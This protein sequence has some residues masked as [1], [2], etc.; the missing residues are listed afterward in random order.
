MKKRYLVLQNGR[1]F[2]GFAFGASASAVGELVFTTGM[3]G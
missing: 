3:G 2:Q 1:V